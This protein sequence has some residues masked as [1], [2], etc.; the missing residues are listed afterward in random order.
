MVSLNELGKNT[1]KES[2]IVRRTLCDEH[3]VSIRQ[4][5]TLCVRYE[6]SVLLSGVRS[7]FSN[8]FLSFSVW[9]GVC[10]SLCV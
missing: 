7:I 6:L 4:N 10:I 2:D 1:F 8:F 3:T 9:L 5:D